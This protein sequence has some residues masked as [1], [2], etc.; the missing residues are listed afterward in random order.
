MTSA[1]RIRLLILSMFVLAGS[2]AVVAR[3]ASLQIWHGAEFRDQARIQRQHIHPL[4]P[5]RG[6]IYDRHGREM[7]ASLSVHAVAAHPSQVADPAA[8]A[9]ILAPLLELPARTIESRLRSR[10]SYIY[11]KRH[12]TPQRCRKIREKRIA[13]IVLEPWNRR[14]YPNASLAAHALGYVSIDGTPLGGIELADDE[15]IRGTDG[16]VLDLTDASQAPFAHRILRKAIPGDSLQLTL[17]L[18]VQY[19]LEDELDRAVRRAGARSGSAVA[20]DPTTGEILAMASWPS[21]NPNTFFKFSDE[22]RRERVVVSAYEPGSTFKVITAAAALEEGLV[23][24]SEVFFCGRGV[25]RVGRHIIHDHKSFADLTF[26]QVLAQSSN[27]GAIKAGLRLAPPTFYATIRRFGFGEKT[28]IG[29]PGELKGLVRPPEVWSLLSQPA[30]SI[31]QEILVT[32]L[33]VISAIGAVANGGVLIRP[34]IVRSLRDESGRL[35]HSFRPPAGRRVVSRKTARLLTAMLQ[36]VVQDGTGKAAAIPGYQAAG[37]TGTAQQSA[38]GVDG[39]AKGKY[40]A[41]FAGYVPA[42]HPRLVAL[43]V[44][45]EPAS[46]RHHGGDVAAPAFSRFAARVLPGLGVAPED[47][48]RSRSGPESLVVR[49]RSAGKSATTRWTA[50]HRTGP[51]RGRSS[52]G[53]VPDPIPPAAGNTLAMPDLVGHTSREAVAVLTS[54]GLTPHLQG[55]GRVRAQKPAAGMPLE[56]ARKGCQ[57]WLGIR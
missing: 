44:I 3:L 36:K 25:F 46:R 20:L 52:G 47:P 38:P 31:G 49:R 16:L 10:A 39:Y 19:V 51:L 15:A 30:L 43:F 40:V 54:L 5:R 35:V 13:G 9:R 6:A 29:L 41:S 55:T 23:T 7:A 8:A 34:W 56:E 18:T 45:N 33:Q 1:A 53:R 2:G 14:V 27:V 24:P 42:A 32:P 26:A 22:E 37:K 57:L 21:F 50:L 12:I 4:K 17:D 48:G 11:L 28:G